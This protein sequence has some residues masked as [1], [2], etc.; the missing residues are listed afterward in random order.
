LFQEL[1]VPE[2]FFRFMKHSPLVDFQDAKRMLEMLPIRF[3]LGPY[4][5]FWLH[6]EVKRA[7]ANGRIFV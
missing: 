7:L 6:R 5:R 1:I 4:D 3:S 2:I